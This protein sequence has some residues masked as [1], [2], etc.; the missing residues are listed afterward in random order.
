MQEICEIRTIK[1]NT[2]EVNLG[3]LRRCFKTDP[4]GVN[5][6]LSLIRNAVAVPSDF[7]MKTLI[8]EDYVLGPGGLI[9]VPRRWDVFNGVPC[10]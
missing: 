8:Q 7:E 3:H 10:S 2:V 1:G 4:F 5:R 6:A 9:S